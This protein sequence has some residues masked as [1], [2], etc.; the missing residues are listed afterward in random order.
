MLL[1]CLLFVVCPFFVLLCRRFTFN[2]KEGI[3]NPVMVTTDDNFKLRPRLCILKRDEHESYGFHLRV[4]KGRKGHVFRNVVPEGIAERSGLQDGDRLLEING[5]FVDDVSHSEVCKKIRLSGNHVCLLVLSGAE[6]EQAECGGQNLQSLS[7]TRTKQLDRCQPPRLCHVTRDPAS[8]LGV[9]FTPV[10]GKR[11]HFGVSLVAGGAAEKAG[12]RKGDRLVWMDGAAVSDLSHSALSRMMRKCKDHITVL[13]IDSDS[14]QIYEQQQMP[15]LPSMAVPQNLPHRARRLRLVCGNDTYGFLLRLEKITPRDIV[16]IL[17]HIEPG[18]PADRAG[19]RDGELLLEV[20]GEEVEPLEHEEVVNKVRES[21][22]E[23]SLTTITF[24][25]LVFY[26]K[27]GLSPL[28]FCEDVTVKDLQNSKEGAAGPKPRLCLVQKGSVGFGFNLGS[29]PH[30]PGTFISLVCD[31]GP[32][33]EAGLL[34]GDTL[35]EVN[36]QN[37]EEKSLEDV[38]V[39]MKEGGKSLSL[40]VQEKNSDDK[41][42]LETPS[43]RDASDCEVRTHSYHQML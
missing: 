33:Q 36:G 8:G 29:S 26:K 42:E 28:L 20:N 18:S 19:L 43:S 6:Y 25:G 31:G 23:V 12:I 7:R 16:H 38:M 22:A 1:S 39:L 35:I 41:M 11:G 17:R 24:Q 15:V 30:R 2:P 3:D 5:C 37:V 34:R 4:E 40:L 9:T 10:E 14:E 13:V 32:G 21:G 27:L